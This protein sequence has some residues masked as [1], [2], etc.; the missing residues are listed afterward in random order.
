MVLKILEMVNE[1]EKRMTKRP[2]ADISMA[3]EILRQH[4]LHGQGRLKRISVKLTFFPFV[5]SIL[6]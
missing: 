2:A 4:A 3:K 6:E 1:F 5:T